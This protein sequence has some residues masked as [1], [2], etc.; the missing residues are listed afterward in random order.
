MVS[1]VGMAQKDD[2]T[3]FISALC[4]LTSRILVQRRRAQTSDIPN[5]KVRSASESAKLMSGRK[6]ERGNAKCDPSSF[7]AWEESA[8][9][10]IP[11]RTE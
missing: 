3:R 8:V 1:H 7:F 4:D 9:G 11:G 5:V 6:V 2:H 10:E